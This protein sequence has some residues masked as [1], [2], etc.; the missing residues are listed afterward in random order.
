MEKEFIYSLKGFRVEPAGT[1]GRRGMWAGGLL[2]ESREGE[3]GV[4]KRDGR[5]S[6]V[7]LKWTREVLDGA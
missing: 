6:E 5:N 4:R 3:E 2:N 7:R 1:Q